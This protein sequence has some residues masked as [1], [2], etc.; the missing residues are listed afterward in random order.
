MAAQISIRG[1]KCWIS[2]SDGPG[3]VRS[4]PESGPQ[5]DVRFQ[6]D[7]SDGPALAQALLGYVSL[8]DDGSISRTA[9]FKLPWAPQLYCQNVGPETPMTPRGSSSDGWTTYELSQFTATF[10]ALKYQVS[11]DDPGGRVDASGLP[12]TTTRFR[13]SSETYS[14][15]TGAYYIAPFGTSAQQISQGSIGFVRPLIDVNMLRHWMAKVPL[16]AAAGLVQCVNDDDITLGDF[17]FAR[18]C[19]LF[20]GMEGD[21]TND[22]TGYPV[23]DIPFNFQGHGDGVEFN[24]VMGDDGEYHLL[25]TKADGTGDPPFAYVSFDPLFSDTI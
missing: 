5:V 20:L 23:F 16:S 10:S 17:T 22:A 3:I 12:Y 21:P 19:L 9:P 15:P 2:E 8:A 1:I 4:W 11:G 24:E 14:P 25:N 13:V 18:G 7:W 6:F